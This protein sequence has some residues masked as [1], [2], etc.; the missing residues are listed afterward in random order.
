MPN[1]EMPIVIIC[2]SL[3][4]LLSLHS[5]SATVDVDP[6]AAGLNGELQTRCYS[7][8]LQGRASGSGIGQVF[9]DS[10]KQLTK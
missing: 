2:R 6:A 1:G 8:M 10:S 9:A 5:I 4:P 7:A 3:Q